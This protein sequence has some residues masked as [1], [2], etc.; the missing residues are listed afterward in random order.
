[1]KINEVTEKSK[2][3]AKG[4]AERDGGFLVPIYTVVKTDEE[5]RVIS[6]THD[7]LNSINTIINE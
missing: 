4:I 7:H 3:R 6:V 1:M 2:E 5:G